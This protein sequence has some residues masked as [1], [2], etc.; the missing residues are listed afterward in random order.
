M[1][2][3]LAAAAVTLGA[4][5]VL[6]IRALQWEGLMVVFVGGCL[7]WTALHLSRSAWHAKQ[8]NQN[9]SGAGHRQLS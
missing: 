8:A 4:V 9:Q 6:M 2:Y 7:W 5:G 3:A 1:R